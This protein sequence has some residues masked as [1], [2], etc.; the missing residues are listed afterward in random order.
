MEVARP[1]IK[2]SVL[3]ALVAVQVLFGINY[4]VSKVIVG[5]YPPLVWASVRIAFAAVA[6]VVIAFAARRPQPPVLNWKFF[7]PMI[8]FSL[9]GIILN[10]G[11]FLLGLKYTTATNSAILNTLIPIFT[12]LIVT[13]RKQEPMTRRRF[14]GFISALAG[15]LVIRKIERFSL[16]DH[17]LIG[18]LLTIFNCLCYAIFLSISKPFLEQYDRV[19]T[20]AWMFILGAVG[21]GLVSIPSWRGFIWPEMTPQLW[22]CV[23]F[24]VIGA[25]LMTYFLNL[26]ALAQVKSSQVAIFIY[27]QP[28]VA[29]AI[30]WAW[31]GEAPTLRTCLAAGLIFCGVLLG[32]GG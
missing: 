4:I 10:Q 12:L 26:W 6:M 17:T 7:G 2:G 1:Q 14:A 28:V 18:D 21:M 8:V 3:A 9:F 5:V 29:A 24:G 25:T 20:T 13:L 16:G 30:A 31:F 22:G 15:V 23:V 32:L 19:W 11:A 27:I